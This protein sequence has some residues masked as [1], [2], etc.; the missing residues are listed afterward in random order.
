LHE[1]PDV[2]FW[3]EI[4]ETGIKAKAK[5]TNTPLVILTLI[6]ILEA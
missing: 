6:R 5:A 3:A 1:L 4:A 2:I